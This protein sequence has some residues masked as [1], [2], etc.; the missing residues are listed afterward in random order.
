LQLQG[1]RWYDPNLYRYVGN[2]APNATDPTGLR[3]AGNPLAGLFG[4]Y[5]GNKVAPYKP[6]NSFVASAALGTF[7]GAPYLV[8]IAVA[9]AL[10]DER[11][12]YESGAILESDTARF[13]VTV[14]GV[15][16]TRLIRSC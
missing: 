8:P 6:V 14:V 2:S 13:T 16:P 11:S 10:V 7:G 5:S 3:Q 4:G 9:A 15:A 12:T 1:A